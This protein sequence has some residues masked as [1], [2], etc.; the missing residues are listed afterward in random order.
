[1]NIL[2]IAFDTLSA[3]HM[4]CYGHTRRT[5]PNLD[6][7]AKA[8]ILCEQMYCPCIPTHPSYTTIFTGQFPVTHQIISHGGSVE[9]DFKRPWLPRLMSQAGFTTCAFDNLARGKRWFLRG[10]EFY[11]DPGVRPL[12]RASLT[13]E[14]INSRALPWLRQHSREKLFMF[15]HYWDTHTP[16]EPPQ[17]Y[18]RLFYEGDDPCDPANTRLEPMKKQIWWDDWGYGVPG[19][20]TWFRRL[21][22][23]FGGREITDA[24]YIRAQYEGEI[25][26]AD[27]HIMELIEALEEEGIA[28]ETLVIITSDHGEMM[29]KHDIFFDH[30]GLYDPDIHVPLIVRWPGGLPG[31][32]RVPALVQHVDLAPTILEAAGVPIPGEMEGTSLLPL[33]RGETDSSPYQAL[34]TEECTRQAKWAIR[35]DRHKFILSRQPD[36]HGTPTRELYDL[37][38]DPQ[39]LNNICETG[40]DLA[41]AL[42]SQLES[43]IAAMVE[44]NA[45][46]DDPVRAQGPS[47]VSDWRRWLE[48]HGYC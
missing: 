43:W 46:E 17:K 47:L 16:Y 27:D 13:C 26:Y 21:S 5:S 22:E 1:M 32:V 3:R 14:D 25:K 37:A 7:L 48:E 45:L 2:L 6:D 15:I 30:H 18:R 35:T 29:Y 44:K 10:W 28:E 19:K 39:E 24:E 33:L 8:S 23:D 40:P 11:I 31:G 34:Y 9:L 38:A 12:S 42:E 36:L 20:R 4:S 41:A